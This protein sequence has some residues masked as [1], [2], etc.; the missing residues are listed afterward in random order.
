MHRLLALLPLAFLALPAARAESFAFT[1]SFEETHPFNADGE[2]FVSNVNGAVT[3]RTWDRNEIRIEG[4]KRA[5]SQEEL[6]LIELTIDPSPSRLRV[7]VKLPRRGPARWFV[8]GNLRANVAFTLT[9]PANAHLRD[10]ATTNGSIK[11]ADVR[12]PVRAESVNGQIEARG[13]AGD[14]SLETVNGTIRA[15]FARLAR[16]QKIST[17]TV[18]GSST[19][20]LPAD[21]SITVDASCVN[22]S[23]DC[24]FP[25]RLNHT[26]GRKHLRG[27]IGSGAAALDAKTVNGSIRVKQL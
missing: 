5:K 18:N 7:K 19:I 16:D 11:I 25:I 1:E 6:D 23:I 26:P 8:G 21:A 24:D 20:S 14:T 10:I 27:T 4:E 15:E 22:G 13:L 12:G 9:V 3:I 2:V 17:A